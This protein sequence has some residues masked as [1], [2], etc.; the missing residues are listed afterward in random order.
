M[1]EDGGSS[2]TLIHRPVPRPMAITAS[3]HRHSRARSQITALDIDL[4]NTLSVAPAPHSWRDAEE[5]V[6]SG[7]GDSLFTSTSADASSPSPHKEYFVGDSEYVS[8]KGLTVASFNLF[9]DPSIYS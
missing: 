4:A 2:G 3:I 5:R 7:F 9:C 6:L 1:S 8:E